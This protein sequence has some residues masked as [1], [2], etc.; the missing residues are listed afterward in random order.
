MRSHRK[1]AQLAPRSPTRS[2]THVA[3]L[4]LD[5]QQLILNQFQQSFPFSS[6]TDLQTTIQTVKGHLYDRNF[7]LAFSQPAYREAYALRWSASRAL[8]YAH[9]FNHL[10]TF[11]KWEEPQLTDGRTGERDHSSR[12]TVV[13]I[14]G[15]AGAEIIALAALLHANHH[16]ISAIKATT[17]DVADW[18]NILLRLHAVVTQPP[19]LSKYASV[20]ARAASRPFGPPDRW[21]SNFLHNDV[22]DLPQDELEQLLAPARLCTIMF[23]LNELFASSVAKTT[24]LLLKITQLMAEGSHLLIV[25]SPGSY[26]EV[27]LGQQGNA[28]QY[29]M[30]WLLDH[31]LLQGPGS[32]KWIKVIS[33]DSRWFR[34]SS[35]LKYPLDL[36]NMRYQ[37][38]L[39]LSPGEGDMCHNL[40][41]ALASLRDCHIVPKITSPALNLDPVVQELL[42]SRRV[43]DLI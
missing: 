18:S 8:A 34:L 16:T 13:C 38:H 15:G 17:I 4:P 12:Y 30:K 29:P 40:N 35:D 28:K 41:L 21:Q 5:L 3:S 10:S 42:E 11:L 20:T 1:T 26:S 14:G 37:I 25:D 7:D 22:L 39:Y 23:T 36:E 27:K 31:A 6:S 33:D 32:E 19:A 43:E 24:A 2:N 9:I